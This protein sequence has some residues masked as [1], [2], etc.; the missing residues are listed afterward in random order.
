MSERKLGTC[1][2]LVVFQVEICGKQKTYKPG[3]EDRDG[4]KGYKF[5]LADSW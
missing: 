4:A 2:I 5:V 3:A 1:W